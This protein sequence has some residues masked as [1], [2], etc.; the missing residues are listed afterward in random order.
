MR[1]SIKSRSG[2]CQWETAQIKNCEYQW[3]PGTSQKKFLGTDE[4]RVAT[5]FQF[6]TPGSIHDPWLKVFWPDS[7]GSNF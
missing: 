5:K 3:V 2:I 7:L 4:Y 6:M 1:V